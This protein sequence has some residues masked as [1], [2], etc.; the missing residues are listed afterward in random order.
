MSMWSAFALW[1]AMAWDRTPQSLRAVGAIA[2]GVIGLILAGGA[3]FAAR[4]GACFERN[5]GSHGRA[6]DR[7]ESLG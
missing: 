3:L 1:A 5:L 4:T 2:V 6:L 7:V